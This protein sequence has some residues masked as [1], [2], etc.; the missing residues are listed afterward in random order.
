M[1]SS[2]NTAVSGLSYFQN[3]LETVGNDI[4]NSNTNGYKSTRVEAADS[5]SQYLANGSPGGAST[6]IGTGVSTSAVSTNFLEGTIANTGVPT[7]LAVDGQGFFVVKDS[8]SGS[9]YATRDGE[10]KT[11]SAGYLTNSSGLRVQGNTTPGAGTATIGDIQIVPPAG[12]TMKS[13]AIGTDG[14]VQVTGTDD[15]TYTVGQVLVQNYTNLNALTKVGGNLYGNLNGAGPL[16]QMTA[17]GSQGTGALRVQALEE[18]NVDLAQEMT[19]LITMQRGY[20]ANARVVTTTNDILQEV[21][22]LKQ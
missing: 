3:Q 17:P 7:D 6:Q 8:V 18:S 13:Y 19:S 2:L 16:A 21:V 12:V 1:F 4:A 15:K 10:F 20:Q 9:S 14:S 22:N 5:F 11:D